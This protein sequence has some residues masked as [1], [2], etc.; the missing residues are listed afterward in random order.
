MV[1]FDFK[2]SRE[3][4]E[5]ALEIHRKAVV[6]DGMGGVP[7]VKYIERMQEGGITAAITNI[8]GWHPRFPVPGRAGLLSSSTFNDS[9][10]LIKYWYSQL[11]RAE[12]KDKMLLATT[13]RDVEKAKREGKTA[14]IFGTQTSTALEGDLANLG[15][16]YRLGMRVIQL[17]HNER[18]I[19][20]DGCGEKTNC[21]LSLF[22][23]ELVEEMNKLGIIVDLAHCGE[24]TT[25]EAI[26]LS[27]DIP[28]F[29]HASVRAICDNPRNKSDEEI[30][31]LAEKGG[32]MGI[33]AF[34]C[35]LN[36]KAPLK[37]TVENY[38][39]HIEYVVKLVGVDHVGIGTDFTP[40]VGPYFNKA[41]PVIPEVLK[42]LK[43]KWPE[44]HPVPVEKFFDYPKGIN[45]TSEVP[46][47]T[48]GLVARGYS[49]GKIEKI[50]GG[51]FL[52]VFRKVWKSGD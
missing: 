17:T 50:L 9:V 15:I 45:N 48:R 16:F 23:E 37:A 35:F 36:K 34:R 11:D 19:A 38:L 40:G 26:E 39:D 44:I 31:A 42:Y 18:T 46:N 21:G 8:M 6:V 29:T 1:K 2:L 47:V 7:N 4:E 41:P 27:K 28:V 30:K 22:G 14:I 5:R 52:R 25:L 33:N 10:E 32:V 3:Q 13:V 51:N 49:D 24:A 12:I 43:R 20:G